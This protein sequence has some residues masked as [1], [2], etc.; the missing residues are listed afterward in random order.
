[1]D[2]NTKSNNHIANLFSSGAHFGFTKRRRHPSV[3][4]YLYGSKD[5][6]DIFDLT[7]TATQLEKAVELMANATQSGKKI[8]F[9][10]TKD[11]VKPLVEDRVKA[12]GA[13]YVVNR[14][15]GGLLTNFSEIRKRVQR[16]HDLL[17]EQESGSLERKYTKKERVVLGR[18]I[19]KL[20]FNFEGVKDMDKKPDLMVVVD[21]RHE[22]IAVKEAHT[23]GIPVIGIM[24]SDCDA[25]GVSYPIMMNDSLQDSV[26]YALDALTEACRVAE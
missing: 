2:T 15:I 13:P 24:S 11:E 6:N 8:L 20:R 22:E 19:E 5:G 1:M 4:P 14:W 7:K 10:G 26:S 17:Q 12:A 3:V 16:L 9:V 18:E 21:P 25:R 23:L